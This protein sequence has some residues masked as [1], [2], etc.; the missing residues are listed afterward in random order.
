MDGRELTLQLASR[1]ALVDQSRQRHTAALARRDAASAQFAFLEL[2]QLE[3]EVGLLRHRQENL[4]IKSPLDGIVVSGDLHRAEGAP[5]AVGQKL[6]EVAPLDRMV[7]EASVPEHLILGVAPGQPVSLVL[8]SHSGVG[9]QGVVLRIHPQAEIRDGQNV[10]IAEVQLNSDD[11]SLLP[12]MSGQA[13]IDVGSRP[14][15]WVLFHRPWYYLR[16][17]LLW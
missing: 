2:E 3:Q 6:F 14:I 4:A 17:K 9:L 13:Q 12:G 15:A 10:F 11:A 16:S 8:D 1:Q 7:V 5:L